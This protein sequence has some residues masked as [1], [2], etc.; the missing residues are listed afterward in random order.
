MLSG[1]G[2]RLRGER[3]GLRCLRD[4]RPRARG[5]RGLVCSV[6]VGARL[7]LLGVGMRLQCR[8]IC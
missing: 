7:G 3:R 5:C 1:R 8:R 4:W 2:S 6:F